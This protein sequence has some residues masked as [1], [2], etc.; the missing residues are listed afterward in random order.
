MT[1]TKY[2]MS[3]VPDKDNYGQPIEDKFIDGKTASGPWAIMNP[4]SYAKH[5]VGLGLGLG[6]CYRRQ[7]D[8]R[9]LKIE[10]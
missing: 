4:T 1:T 6:Q 7:P 8:G 5:G 3:L 10:G 9:W 2:W